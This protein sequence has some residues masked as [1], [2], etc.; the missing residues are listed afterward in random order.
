[1][2]L[3]DDLNLRVEQFQAEAEKARSQ[4]ERYE[5]LI[6]NARSLL[7]E[8]EK[9]GQLPLPVQVNGATP[10][11]ADRRP[12]VTEMIE[13]VVPL[14][15]AYRFRDVR[16][17]VHTRWFTGM[18]TVEVGKRVGAALDRKV[19][20]GQIRRLSRGLYINVPEENE[21]D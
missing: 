16:D 14:T 5:N 6:A 20:R 4:V 12:T 9:S 8:E 1:M 10:E 19:R 7:E 21:A 2:S 17:A 18:A 3:R 13:Q 15:R 11:E